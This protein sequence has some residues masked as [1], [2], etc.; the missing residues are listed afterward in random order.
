MNIVLRKFLLLGLILILLSFGSSSIAFG[1]EPTE[2]ATAEPTEEATAEPTEEATAEPTEEATAEPTEEATAEPTE[3]ATAEPTVEATTEPTQEPTEEAT[4]EPTQEPTAEP[5]EEAT[6]EP[7]QELGAASDDVGASVVVNPPGQSSNVLIQNLTNNQATV[8]VEVFNTSGTKIFNDSFT[9]AGKGARTVHAGA[10]TN[11]SGHL[12]M[13]LPD[14]SQ[15]AMVVQSTERVVAANVNFGSPTVHNVYE[16][17]D[18]S[19]TATDILVPSIHWRDAQWS[20]FSVQNAG[21][22]PANVEIK[23]FRQDGSQIGSTI[24]TTLQPGEPEYRNA[25][26]D[27]SIVSEP[28]GVG[29]VRV[30]SSNSQPLAVAIMETLFTATYSYSGIPV[31]AQDTKWTFPSVHRNPSGQHSHI[32][33]QNTSS[34]TD[35]NVTLTYFN[36]SGT[37]VNTFTNITIPKSGA[38]TF[39]TTNELSGDGGNYTPTN[40]GNVGSAAVEAT[41]GVNLVATVV[42]TVGANPYSYNGF[43]SSAGATNVLL[44]SVHR[45]P[46]G[47]FSHTLACNTSTSQSNNIQLTYFNQDGSTANTFTKN[48]PASGCLTFHTTNELS[49]DGVNYTPSN[50]GNVGSAEIVSLDSR[51]IVAVVVETVIGLPGSYAGFK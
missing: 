43:N 23:Y 30:T 33:V 44:P 2:E 16:G 27:V 38:L 17:T 24:N 39:H 31:S 40:L 32:L 46:G 49:G 4:A 15:S 8:S 34:S 6:A 35:A 47:Q 28:A 25:R 22:G 1:Q 12:Y 19:Q 10:G 21:T 41:N 3:E 51:N 20:L 37:V 9:L 36:Q 5:T 11:N 14:G 13:N 7:T 29:S 50:L 26:N 42:E 48:L 18:S 45:N